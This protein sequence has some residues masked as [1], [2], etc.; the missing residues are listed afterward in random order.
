MSRNLLALLADGDVHSGQ[1]LG[2]ILGISRAAVCKQIRKLSALGLDIV[3]AKGEGYRLSAPLELLRSDYIC[4]SLNAEVKELIPEIEVCWSIPSTNNHCLAGIKNKSNAGYVCVAEHQ[5]AGRGR[6]GR[7]WVS[8]LA[9][10]LY[11]S[12]VWQFTGGAEVLEGLSLAVAIVVATTL[13]EEYRL[14]NVK[15]KWPND[16]L[17]ND[18]KIGGILIEVAGEA[19]GP[20]SVVIGIGLNVKTSTMAE[21]DIDQS[22]TDLNSA[23]GKSISRNKLAALVLNSLVPLLQGY[24]RNG[25]AEHRKHWSKYDAYIGKSVVV[26]RGGSDYIEGIACGISDSGELLLEV[27]GCKQAFKSGEVS[28]RYV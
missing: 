14:E 22:W 25:F 1:A 16:I 10:S 5:S 24:E 27:N 21:R 9:G 8:P 19:G 23:L 7:S 15:L 3:S 11:L 18:K 6:R 2:D 13:R 26:Y 17:L 20:C 4:G 28:L 12:L